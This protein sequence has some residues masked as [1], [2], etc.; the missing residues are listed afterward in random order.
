MKWSCVHEFRKGTEKD[1]TGAM[2]GVVVC[3][4]RVT[5][6]GDEEGGSGRHNWAA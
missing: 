4:P 6:R 3:L 2:K 1:V 5:Y